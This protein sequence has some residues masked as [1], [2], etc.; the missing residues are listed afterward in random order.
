MASI[1]AAYRWGLLFKR[2]IMIDKYNIAYLLQPGVHYIQLIGHKK[3]QKQ[4]QQ[5]QQVEGVAGMDTSN[6]VELHK[7]DEYLMIE[8]N[9]NDVSTSI[10]SSDNTCEE[11][12]HVEYDEF[13]KNYVYASLDGVELEGPTVG[14]I[15][16]G[17]P[18]CVTTQG[19]QWNLTSQT[20]CFGLLVSS[21]NRI[22]SNNGNGSSSIDSSSNDN[23][24]VRIETDAPLLWTHEWFSNKLSSY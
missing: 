5:Q 23:M 4:L 7:S 3:D 8:G 16:V 9:N 21:S 14:L 1:Q 15:P 24:G 19:L 12:K 17:N 10:T 11:D 6:G 18:C 13:E 2:F 22:A 20:L